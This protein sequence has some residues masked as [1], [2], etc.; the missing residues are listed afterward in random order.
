MFGELFSKIRKPQSSPAEAPSHWVKCSHCNSLMYYKEVEACHN[1]CPKCGYHMR[2]NAKKRIELLADEGSFKEFDS[3]LKPND[4]LNFVDKKSYKKRVSEG[5]E[6][7]GK[8]SS[9]IAGEATIEKK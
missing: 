6:K 2:I 3:N 4:P 8:T 5:V 9:V 1:V 7:T